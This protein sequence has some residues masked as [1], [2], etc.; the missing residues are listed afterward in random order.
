MR[1]FVLRLAYD[2]SRYFG[3]QKTP[4]GPSI[5]QTLQEILEKILDEPVALQAASR[6]D[7]GVHAEGQMVNFFTS[8][9]R[10]PEQIVKSLNALLP[11][12]IRILEGWTAPLSFHPTLHA[13]RKQY[14]YFICFGSPQLPT[15]RLFSWHIVS[16]LDL[17]KMK[18]AA[19]A[20]IGEH[21]FSAFCNIRKNLKYPHKR[22]LLETIDLSLTH[23]GHL[24]IKITGNQ[25]LYK[26]VR[27]LVGTLVDVGKGKRQ[28][29][30]IPFILSSQSRLYAGVTAPAHGLTLAKIFYAEEF[31]FGVSSLVKKNP[32]I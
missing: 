5:E 16:Q 25:F 29:E 7:R 2:G 20:F 15:R 1:N 14:T 18:Q 3:W 10:S 11:N 4:T 23:P 21:D 6:T 9:N 26:M 28:P 13:L 27:T 12:D 31:P 8:K 30:E 22:R 24:V 19:A 32:I 17:E